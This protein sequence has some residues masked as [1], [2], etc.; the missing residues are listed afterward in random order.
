[1]FSRFF[2]DR[3]IFASVLSIVITLTGVLAL[4]SLP[5]AQYPEITPPSVQ[6]AIS[7]PGASAQVVADTV[8]APIEQQ[9]NGVEGM[10]YMTSQSGNDGSYTLTVTFEI[11]TDLNTALVMVQNRVTLALPQ[12]PTEV[13]LQGITIRKKTPDILQVITFTSPNGQYDN[14]YLSNFATIYVKDELLRIDGVS[15]INYFGQRDYSI[16]IWLDPQKMAARNISSADVAAAVRAQNIEAAPGRIGQPP[17]RPDLAFEFPLDTLGRLTTPEQFGE[18]IV[19]AGTPPRPPT[20]VPTTGTVAPTT[21]QPG[22]T[23]MP[24]PTS[25]NMP[26]LVGSA[27]GGQPGGVM[28]G[29][30]GSAGGSTT[31]TTSTTS[32][33]STLGTSYNSVAATTTTTST[34]A[35]TAGT[36]PATAT[37][38]GGLMVGGATTSGL[39]ASGP[40][41]GSGGLVTPT[42]TDPI[43]AGIAPASIATADLLTAFGMGQPG[44]AAAAGGQPG[45]AA[46]SGVVGPNALAG[47]TL[48]TGP[49][50]AAGIVRLRDIARLELA[51][52]NYTNGAAFDGRPTVGLG[53]HLLPGSNALAVATRVRDKMTELG[54][55]FPDGVE[56]NIAYDITPFIQESIQDVIRTLFEAT[57]LVALVVLLFLQNWRAAVI[58]LVA[59]PVAIL[60][61]FAV[62]SGL[63]FTLNNI[64]L[65]GLVL[66][67]GIVVDDAIVVVENVERW[68]ERGHPP[69]EAAYKA[70]EEVTGP[71][72]A[73][74]LVL[75]AVFVPCAFV[76]GITGQFFRQFAVTITASTIFSAINSL[77]LSP[78]LAAILM[79]K[80]DA[81][82]DVA[83][84]ALNATLGWF[85][86]LFNRAFEAGTGAY[87]WVIRWVLRVS[88]I[89][90]VLY[91]GLLGLTYWVFQ[92]APTGFVPDQDQG[93]LIVSVQLPDSASLQRTQDVLTQVDAI[94]RKTPGVAHTT[95]VAGISLVMSANSSN[96]GT[97]FLVLD[98]FANRQAPGLRADA[99]MARLR[100]EVAAVQD[101]DVK[102]F[103][104]PPVPGLSVASGYKVMVEDRGG[105][106]LEPLQQRTD[107]LVAK[108]QTD[109]AVV[110]T[111]TQFRS[112]TPQL[113]LDVDR[114]KVQSLGIQLTD[115]DQTMQMNL[116]SLYVNSFNEFGR[117]W[118]VT[119]QAEGRFRNRIE[120]VDL[121]QVRTSGGDMVPL[122]TLV[123]LRE[124]N[125][126]VS[127]NRYNLYVAAAVT[128]N[129]R[130]GVSSGQAIADVE[131]AATEV[132]PRSMAIE[133]TELMFLQIRAGN[134]AIYVFMVAVVFVFL[135][136][137]ALYESWALPLAV[138]LVV[139]LCL[140][141][142]VSGVLLT[143][144]SVDIFVQ[145]GFIVL[146]GL[147]CKNAILIVEFAHT[148]H[149]EGRPRAEAAVEASRLRLRPILMT[150]MAFI[151]GVFPLVIATGAGAEMRQS[152]GTAVFS[153]M[154]GVTLFGIFLTPVFYTLIQ[155]GVDS[156]VFAQGVGRWAGSALLGAALG[157]TVGY[158]AAKL[159]AGDLVELGVGGGVAGALLAI[160]LPS[161]WR[162]V[163]RRT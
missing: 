148:L 124:V 88:L 121:L 120:N 21:P 74:A 149:Q 155:R 36:G 147:A 15:D 9:V 24:S 45:P 8:A 59:V 70:M 46:T 153:G 79:R 143:G 82:P 158:S 81:R 55:R 118:Q 86:R 14:I 94:A 100:K 116:G 110:G 54:P 27:T 3:P 4:L 90:L 62:M 119:A 38:N 127:I 134:T 105:S 96:L 108:L 26:G 32:V 99:I 137:A 142:S 98:P 151:L 67:I 128:G 95:S 163:V 107:A 57:G 66:A 60:G 6:V 41:T 92:K 73:I 65:F 130:P 50:P 77:T 48:A 146:V 138:I 87:A 37:A 139:P 20:F 72:V 29:M 83:T 157:A 159:G 28:A 1:M 30:T 78:A 114:V 80:H 161:L 18:I 25:P 141:C 154:L 85:F 61:T 131:A 156:K 145:I 42:T 129:V 152:L 34:T 49:W 23:G 144:L 104:A 22:G 125:G 16:R 68:L 52:Q 122:G 31:S 162:R 53:I 64:S 17:V 103:G 102:V 19:K 150:S 35:A 2:I 39:N 11:G 111:L 101:A 76:G 40:A 132:L 33:P 140:L 47:G 12:L 43:A 136:L 123:R 89:V 115:V 10:L 44:A 160:I 5:V 117:Y 84:R 75:C 58:P 109:P 112:K 133:W 93:R 113:F 51:A 91:G 13:Q 7:Y 97:M 126:P 135:A 106:G 69:R 56:Y 63:G 71:V